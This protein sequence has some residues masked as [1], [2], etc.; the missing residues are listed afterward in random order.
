MLGRNEA[1]NPTVTKVNEG[2]SQNGASAVYLVEAKRTASQ[3]VRR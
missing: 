1:P 2:G 3:T